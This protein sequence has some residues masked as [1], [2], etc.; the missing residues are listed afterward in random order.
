MKSYGKFEVPTSCQTRTGFSRCPTVV[1]S[2][3][4]SINARVVGYES[5]TTA[6]GV[7]IALRIDEVTTVTNSTN[8]A[9]PGGGYSQTV[10]VWFDPVLGGNIK[11]S[12]VRSY[13]GTLSTGQ[14]ASL[15]QSTNIELVS[16]V[17]N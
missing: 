1:D 3:D 12:G 2:Q 15:I 9:L 17:K 6:A 14:A 4:E 16:Y 7:F 8:A 11:F 13:N 5:L 10:S